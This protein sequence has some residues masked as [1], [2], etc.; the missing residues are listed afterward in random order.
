M[1]CTTS[2]QQ[3]LVDPPTTSNDTNGRTGPTSDGLLGTTWQSDA[4]L[5]VIRVVSN[6]G[7]VVA[8]CTGEGTTV[9]WALLN[10][11]D[12][13][14]F[15]QLANG[16]DVADGQSRLF[17]AVDECTGVQAFG[18]NEGFLAELVAVRVAENDAGERCTTK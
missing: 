12:D 11:A 10:V 9:T 18:G 13:G 14:T 15:G 16:E 7:S 2:L 5:V 3:R 4:S 17:A 1:E 6:D 8:G